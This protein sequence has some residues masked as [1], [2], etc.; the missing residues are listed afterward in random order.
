[1]DNKRRIVFVSLLCIAM[2]L[3]QQ[4]TCRA[5]TIFKK[6]SRGFTNIATGSFEL[7]RQPKVLHDE[8]GY[9]GLAAVFAGIFTGIGATVV[10]ELC[11]VYDVVTCP[12]P[13]PAE[14]RSLIDPPTVFDDYEKPRDFKK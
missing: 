5:D 10:R 12:I 14:Y 4:P 6:F 3:A 8:Y 7:F 2:L 1:M 13:F 11:G 9:N